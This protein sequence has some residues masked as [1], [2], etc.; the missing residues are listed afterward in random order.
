MDSD[1]VSPAKPFESEWGSTV[2]DLLPQFGGIGIV[3]FIP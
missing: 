2:T 3:P 1:V